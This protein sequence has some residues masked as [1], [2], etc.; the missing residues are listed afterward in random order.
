[1][2]PY[3]CG[4]AIAIASMVVFALVSRFIFPHS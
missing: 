4:A 3:I 2:G 1:M